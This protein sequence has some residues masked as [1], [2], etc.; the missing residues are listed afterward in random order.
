MEIA[1]EEKITVLK[2]ILE[3]DN[4]TLSLGICVL[5]SSEMEQVFGKSFS[6]RYASRYIPEF[7]REAAVDFGATPNNYIWWWPRTPEGNAM[8]REFLMSILSKLESQDTASLIDKKMND[9]G[10]F[11]I[12]Q[13]DFDEWKAFMEERAKL[14]V[15]M[16]FT[17]KIYLTKPIIKPPFDVVC[18]N[19]VLYKRNNK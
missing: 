1:R 9:D 13:E 3:H 11:R 17:G 18:Y 7:N 5:I 12:S 16:L 19:G 6:S 2:R 10:F 4:A 8:R 14:E 15:E